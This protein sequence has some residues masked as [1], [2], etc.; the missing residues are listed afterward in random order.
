MRLYFYVDFDSS[1]KVN[2]ISKNMA[3]N[4]G[5]KIYPYPKSYPLGWVRKKI[6]MKVIHQRKLRFS[7]SDNYIGKV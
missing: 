6:H 5:L 1:S 7:I 2:M 4:L 3:K